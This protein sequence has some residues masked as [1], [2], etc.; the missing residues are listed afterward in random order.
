MSQHTVTISS[1]YDASP[2]AFAV[3]SQL[4]TVLFVNTSTVAV[5]INP[6]PPQGNG[7]APPSIVVPA[8]TPGGAN[9][10]AV[11]HLLP[12]STF[13]YYVVPV[14]T[15]T[16]YGPYGIE[17]SGNPIGISIAGGNATPSIVAIPPNGHLTF[18]AQDSTTYTINWNITP[19]PFSPAITTINSTS[20]Y[21]CQATVTGN[22][23]YTIASPPPG[24]GKRNGGTVK[25]VGGRK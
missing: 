12:Y 14:G 4:D 5:S 23:D 7:S 19:N 21:N 6:V 18:L 17:I 10:Q 20:G 2:E 25:V 1:S 13:N 11:M 16:S 8:A 15:S 3:T 24:H 22:L 9:G